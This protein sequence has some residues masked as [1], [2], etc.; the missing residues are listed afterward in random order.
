VPSPSPTAEASSPSPL[1]E[2]SPSPLEASSPSPPEELSSTPFEELSSS[3]LETPSPSPT[4]EASRP[5]PL[6]ELSSSPLEA[7]SLS[8]TAKASSP[9]PPEELSSSPLEVT[10]P[11]ETS[12][13]PFGATSPQPP[14]RP[15]A[16]VLNFFWMRV[17][18]HLS[19]LKGQRYLTCHRWGSR[20]GSWLSPL[21]LSS[22]QHR[23]FVDTG[24]T[25]TEASPS[26][27]DS[28]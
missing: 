11:S 20:I 7:P 21:I 9:S 13:L 16:V 24:P 27:S 18:V 8:P 26:I 28:R 5:S 14:F 19:V 17:R 10:S 15:S 23:L 22:Y 4:D 6:E 25:P 2:L 3:P 12:P 1:E